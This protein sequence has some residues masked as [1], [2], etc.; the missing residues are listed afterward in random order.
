MKIVEKKENET[1]LVEKNENMW[2]GEDEK[3]RRYFQ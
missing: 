1:V 2:Y 3:K